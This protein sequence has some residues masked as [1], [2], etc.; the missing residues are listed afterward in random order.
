VIATAAE[1]IIRSETWWGGVLQNYL[2]VLQ[3]RL[4]PPRTKAS[5]ADRLG[6]LDLALAEDLAQA[7]L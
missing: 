2:T 4:L 3:E 7:A 5:T 6:G 1:A